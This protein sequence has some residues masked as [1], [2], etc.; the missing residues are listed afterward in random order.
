[1]L[2]LLR[3]NAVDANTFDLAVI[4][5]GS[6][7]FSA[8][9]TAAEDGAR[10]ALIGY[11]TIG[12][13]CVNVGCV[14]S[15]AMIR[16]V[17]TLHSAKSADRFNGVEATARVTDW[18]AMVAQKQALVD[19]LRAAKYVDVLPNYEGVTY[20]EGQASFSNDGSLR[21]GDRAIRAPKV[22]IATGSAQHI[23]DI[24]G[25]DGINWLDSTSALEQA[26]LPKSL[27]VMGGGYIGV[28]IAQIFSRAGVDVTIVTRRGL[29]PEAEPEVSDALTKAF[30]DEGIKVLDG[31]AYDRFEKSG[32]GVT[33][34]AAHNGVAAR[35]EAEKLLLA[36]G[37]C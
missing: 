12:G 1:M 23:P 16:A 11:G 30:A 35:I 4:G 26:Q 7:G 17:E 32:D 14:P 31:L 20:I 28:E 8:A 19:D 22:V 24:P 21:V 5:A 3:P 15:K 13:T 2:D 18:A 34:H 10:V 6:A 29:L 36:T 37:R 25:L 27:M 9:I 33:L